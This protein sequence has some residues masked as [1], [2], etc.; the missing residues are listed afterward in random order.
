MKKVGLL[1]YSESDNYGAVL[2]AYALFDT[3]KGIYK[4]YELRIIRYTPPFMVGRYPIFQ[5]NFRTKRNILFNLIYLYV[6]LVKKYRFKKFRQKYFL[7]TKK[8]FNKKPDDTFDIYFVGSD[9]VWNL[10]LN[11]EDTTYLLDFVDS[12][13][14]KYSFAASIATANYE[15]YVQVYNKYVRLFNYISIRE[16][17]HLIFVSS[18]NQN[19]KVIMDSVFLKKREEWEKMAIKSKKKYIYIYL[20]KTI[21][22][23]I[24]Y[25]IISYANSIGNEIIVCGSFPIESKIVHFDYKCGPLQFLS[26]IYNANY[27]FTDSFHCTAFSV[28][29]NKNFF[30][31][32]YPGTS[33]RIQN[34]LSEVGLEDRVLDYGVL[35]IDFDK[36]DYDRINPTLNNIRNN[37]INF[38]KKVKSDGETNE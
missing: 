20:F 30:S 37:S 31:F 35:E 2:Q 24:A 38:L 10:E 13:K 21:S 19:S 9:Q 27:V 7:Y 1:T 17:E 14:K 6:N 22:I 16:K 29:F 4:D 34:L 32:K 28:I 8:Y 5:Y 12:K 3:L 26:Y 18:I 33:S 11:E 36:I 23:E 15:K 25:Q